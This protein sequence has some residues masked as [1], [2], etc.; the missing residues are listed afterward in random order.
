MGQGEQGEAQRRR[1][2]GV[3][4]ATSGTLSV[5][6]GQETL[7]EKR[8]GYKK[9]TPFLPPFKLQGLCCLVDSHSVVSQYPTPPLKEKRFILVQDFLEDSVHS[10]PTTRQE[11]KDG[12][13]WQR[14]EG[15]IMAARKQ[16]REA[17]PPVTHISQPGPTF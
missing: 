13:D 11:G 6:Q 16:R 12:K 8:N 2:S 3:H 5:H 15:P 4:Y 7:P 17:T 10:W 1:Y 9:G 14:K